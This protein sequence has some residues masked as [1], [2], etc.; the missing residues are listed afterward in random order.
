MCVCNINCVVFTLFVDTDRILFTRQPAG[1]RPRF[2][3]SPLISRLS[4]LSLS[5][6]NGMCSC[7]LLVVLCVCVE[8]YG[9]ESSR[10]TVPASA[11]PLTL[12][13]THT[14]AATTRHWT[15]KHMITRQGEEHTRDMVWRGQRSVSPSA[16]GTPL[17]HSTRYFLTHSL[18]LDLIV[19]LVCFRFLCADTFFSPLFFVVRAPFTLV[20]AALSDTISS[21]AVARDSTRSISNG[22]EH[23]GEGRNTQA[24]EEKDTHDEMQWKWRVQPADSHIILEVNSH[25]HTRVRLL[26]C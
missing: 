12:T 7:S 10:A 4:A 16:A 1:T 2:T 18:A 5:H 8:S 19:R 15:S 13:R 3:L 14:R 25:A 23:R 11:T 6:S 9:V 21:G 17:V 22:A 20:S 26:H 24:K